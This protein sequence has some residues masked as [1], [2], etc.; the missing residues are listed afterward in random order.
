MFNKEIF[1][2]RLK[3]LRDQKKISTV[4]LAK[5]IGISKQAISQFEKELTYPHCNTLCSLADYFDV[6]IDY[7]VGRSD[8]PTRH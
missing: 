2:T 6:S 1:A 4:G 8:D 5:E 7:L 3:L